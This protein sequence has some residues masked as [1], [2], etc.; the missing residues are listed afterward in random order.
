MAPS[1][2]L[3]SLKVVFNFGKD[4][5]KIIPVKPVRPLKKAGFIDKILTSAESRSKYGE[6]C[7]Q[8]G[9]KERDPRTSFAAVNEAPTSAA[10]DALLQKG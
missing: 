1:K 7:S 8:L 6:R 3:Q 10:C 5:H 4:I 9:V 2:V